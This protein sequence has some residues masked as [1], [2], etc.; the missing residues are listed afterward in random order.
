MKQIL[1][2][3][4]LLSVTYSC[5]SQDTVVQ[6]P[7]V[8][9]KIG[10]VLSGG[11]AKGLAHI[12]LLKAID[13]AGLKIDYITGT[14]M[15]SVFGSMYA[16]GYS[17][18]SIEKIARNI[19]WDVLLSNQSSLNTMVMDEKE[20]YGKYAIEM[21]WVNHHFRLPGGFLE[22]QEIWL[23]LGEIFFPVYR[24]KDFDKFSIPFKCMGTDIH[25][26]SLVV[27]DTGEIL[28]AV[29][30]SFAIP[31]VFTP[32]DVY[33]KKV[34]DGGVVRNFP[35]KNVREMG[36]GYVIG[37]NT[38]SVTITRNRQGNVLQIL[39]QIA[40]FGDA[41]DEKEEIKL[42]DLYIPQ[43]IDKFS[44]ASFSQA[45]EIIDSGIQEGRRIYPRL[46][47]LVDS[48]DSIY[49]PQPEF[50]HIL[51]KT[52]SVYIS[53]YEI[54]GLRH[55]SE[56][57]FLA[58]MDFKTHRS[59]TGKMLSK[60]MLNVF[61]TR[62]YSRVIYSLVPQPDGS[63][64][65]IIEARESPLTYAK[66]G[67][68]YTEFE[69]VS[70]IANL[71]SRNFISP[72]SRDLVTANIGQN[73]RVKG[74]HLQYMG[75]KKR[76]TFLLGMRYETLHFNTYDDYTHGG[77]FRNFY[78]NFDARIQQSVNRI[79]TIGLGTRFERIKYKPIIMGKFAIA[80]HNQ[81]LS[82][83]L[84]TRVN[85]IDRN[86]FPREGWKVDGELG[87]VYTQSPD[88]IYYRNALPILDTDSLRVNFSTYQRFLV[89][90]EHYL[91]TGRGTT[92]LTSVA[93]GINFN[94]TENFM[95]DFVIGGLNY[96]FRNQVPFAGLQEGTIYAPNA[97]AVLLG[98]RKEIYSSWYVTAK[99]NAA[100]YNF[101]DR[102]NH[103][104]S[105]SFLSG[106]ALS[107][108][109]NMIL[110]PLEFSVMYCDQ[111]RSVQTYVNLGISF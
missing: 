96:S 49:G 94:S 58:M 97:A 46:K 30:A 78:F 83:Y 36:A 51:P 88:I 48:L 18:D 57:F 79:F 16:I 38:S 102:D 42:C 23:T 40:F 75:R 5:L 67:L 106:Y 111:S 10:L 28:T 53:S 24:I 11:G 9:P 41:V 98:L 71:T 107:F 73:F 2:T 22:S 101:L 93:G 74:E 50:S 70:A 47:S 59:Y 26:G 25:D 87:V 7:R 62:Y 109:Y 4:L 34:L 21:P 86:Y 84:F 64:K 27:M 81:F 68:R 100:I 56:A 35:V 37:S 31:T 80:G 6:L 89:T 15:G 54:Q 104:V 103:W 63:A 43:P 55:T 99:A 52:D 108:G 20:E 44:A 39:T 82:S 13:S 66:A 85:T 77:S 91:N 8:R 33:G 92:F 95:N 19:N 110:G 65:I 76:S 3:W 105:P 90:A 14:S 12:G 32:V 1:I 61:G 17:G 60:K 29:R 69:G 45:S 72:F